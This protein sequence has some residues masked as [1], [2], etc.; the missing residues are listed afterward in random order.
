M[1]RILR[2]PAIAVCALYAG[3]VTLRA[4][5]PDGAD[6]LTQAAV[7]DSLTVLRQLD[8]TLH[9]HP[10]DAATWYRRGMLAWALYERD[11]NKPPVAGLDWT[12]LGQMADTSLRI[13]ADL[14][15]TSGQYRMMAGRF[16][17][18]SGVAM[19]RA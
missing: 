8:S 5:A 11:R 15:G 7:A 9:A 6:K 3:A 12:R 16:L 1:R 10:R 19:T 17:L 14:D 2:C 13:A 4:Q 18:S